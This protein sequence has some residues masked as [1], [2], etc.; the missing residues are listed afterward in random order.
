M[1]SRKLS[2]RQVK[3]TLFGEITSSTVKITATTLSYKMLHVRNRPT[4]T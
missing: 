3:I 4:F 1:Q 2:E